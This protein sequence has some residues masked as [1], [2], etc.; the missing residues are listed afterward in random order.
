M[1]NDSRK[2][3]HKDGYYN[4][5]C[6]ICGQKFHA[7]LS[8]IKRGGGK[9]CSQKCHYIAK[10]EYM[11]GEGNHQYGL[12]GSLNSSWISDVRITRYGYRAIRTPDHP[13]RDADDYVLEHRLIAEKYLLTDENSVEVNGKRYLS[14][15]YVVH[16]INFDRLDNRVENLKVMKKSE[17]Q[18][19]HASLNRQ[20]RDKKTGRFIVSDSIKIKKVSESAI[21]PTRATNGSAGYDLYVDIDEPVEIKAHETTMLQTNIAF[22]I[23]KGYFGAV[24][25]RS[26]LASK[27]GIRPSTC[28]SVI[29][30]DYRGSV[31]VPLHNDR[32]D[33][34][35][36]NP[37]ERVAQIVFIP[38][39]EYE[40]DV[41]DELDVTDRDCGGFGSTGV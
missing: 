34:F 31:G 1:E 36:I 16:H 17:H 12:K 39:M 21:V 22:S 23:P 25:A 14:H 4:C 3:K 8:Q 11:K 6:K 28:V 20:E 9:Y 5:E 18:R 37:H 35:V 33:S 30:S 2:V 13:F 38:A 29:D 15:E 10:Q 19:Y 24:F 7:K 27:H 41:V 40:L 26:G 32:D